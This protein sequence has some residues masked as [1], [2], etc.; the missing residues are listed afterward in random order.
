[1]RIAGPHSVGS[2]SGVADGAPRGDSGAAAEPEAGPDPDDGTGDPPG[3]DGWRPQAATMQAMQA[4]L[5]M[6]QRS[7][8]AG[9]AGYWPLYSSISSAP[10]A[11]LPQVALYFS[12]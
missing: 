10:L 7:A 1:M 5:S 6:P 11:K 8:T 9:R 4:I 3:G 2:H 12:A